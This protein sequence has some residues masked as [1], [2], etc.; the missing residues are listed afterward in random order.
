M[1]SKYCSNIVDEYDIEMG[2]ANKLF[3]N[4]GNKS[5]YILHIAEIV[6][7]IFCSE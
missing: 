6:N 1:L 3:P 7:S 5:K 4:L 2:G